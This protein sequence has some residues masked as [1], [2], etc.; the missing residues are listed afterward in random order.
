MTALGMK[1]YGEMIVWQKK[2]LQWAARLA[3]AWGAALLA[4]CPSDLRRD[5]RRRRL[6]P[7]LG[8]EGPVVRGDRVRWDAFVDGR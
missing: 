7:E 2:V 1:R 8:A 4:V 5:G 6:A 3:V